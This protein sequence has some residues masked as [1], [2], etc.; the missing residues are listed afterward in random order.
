M[1]APGPHQ[2]QEPALTPAWPPAPGEPA[3]E[4]AGGA[5]LPLA[6]L[7]H[8]GRHDGW[9]WHLVQA[10]L[11]R[12][13][14]TSIAPDLP[15]TS[16][17]D[18][19]AA[20][21]AVLERCSGRVILVGHSRAGRVITTAAS[22]CAAVQRLIYVAGFMLDP[23]EPFVPRH[24]KPAG[25]RERTRPDRDLDPEMAR[26]IFYH[27]VPEEL[28]REAVRHLRVVPAS[29]LHQPRSARP[30][31]WRSIPSTYVVCTDDHHI[32]PDDQRE[33]ARR[34]SEVV[35]I[36]SS[37]AP[38]LSVPGALAAIIAER[39]GSAPIATAPNLT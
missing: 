25:D 12:R 38:F 14:I 31:A 16:T 29:A 15:F 2:H 11:T 6:V 7:V 5:R 39:V 30:A 1:V 18:D 10:E 9:S 13:G 22:G 32:D 36:H 17:E 8:G 24:P 19:I 4:P 20:V 21:R 33:M 23:G 3:R 28:F 26:E 37:H 34:A 35:E 27:D